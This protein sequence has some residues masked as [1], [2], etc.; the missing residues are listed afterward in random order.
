MYSVLKNPSSEV[1]NTFGDINVSDM[2]EVDLKLAPKVKIT[3]YN[4]FISMFE[5]APWKVAFLKRNLHL[6]HA[7]ELYSFLR[8]RFN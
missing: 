8:N 3:K 7:F 2:N 5:K 4:Q 6:K 1:V